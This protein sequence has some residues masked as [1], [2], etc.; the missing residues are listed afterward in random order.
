[1][2]EKEPNQKYFDIRPVPF[3]NDDPIHSQLENTGKIVVELQPT[4]LLYYSVYPILEANSSNPF[5][6]LIRLN[7]NSRWGMN[8]M[9][10][11]K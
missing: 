11:G 8:V 2:M 9:N 7:Q 4:S 1:M 10:D 3:H 5:N 6:S